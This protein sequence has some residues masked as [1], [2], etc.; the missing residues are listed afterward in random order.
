MNRYT[1][2]IF[3]KLRIHVGPGW[4]L[5]APVG[6]P[7]ENSANGPSLNKTISMKGSL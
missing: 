3:H 6:L 4:A 2:D 5:T 1:K 7:K